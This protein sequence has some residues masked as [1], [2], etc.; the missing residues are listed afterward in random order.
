MVLRCKVLMKRSLRRDTELET[1]MSQGTC[2]QKN[3]DWE[4]VEY[5]IGEPPQEN[6]GGF[7]G[8][9]IPEFLKKSLERISSN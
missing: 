7:A 9:N 2:I 4:M 6:P 5:R 1:R 3:L 8:E